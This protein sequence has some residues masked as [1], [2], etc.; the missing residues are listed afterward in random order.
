MVRHW[1]EGVPPF[2]LCHHVVNILRRLKGGRALPFV[3][4]MATVGRMVF[5]TFDVCTWEEKLRL[6]C[7]FLWF[8]QLQTFQHW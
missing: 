6:V 5:L 7:L 8:F 4:V 3:S 2:L 1:N